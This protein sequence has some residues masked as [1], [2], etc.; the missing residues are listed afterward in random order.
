MY[1]GL[2]RSELVFDFE[3]ATGEELRRAAFNADRP[4]KEGVLE[5]IPMDLGRVKL[6]F[7]RLEN[8]TAFKENFCGYYDSIRFMFNRAT[9]CIP[10]IAPVLNLS[11]VEKA[12]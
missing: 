11:L 6:F 3:T 2:Q 4:L 10:R 9:D 1:H 7:N 5:W 12:D 8:D